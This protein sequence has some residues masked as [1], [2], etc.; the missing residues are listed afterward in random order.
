M[1]LSLRIVGIEL[2]RSSRAPRGIGGLPEASDN[3][4][5]PPIPVPTPGRCCLPEP[6]AGPDTR[7]NRSR[8]IDSD[9]AIRPEPADPRTL[10]RF[11]CDGS[12]PDRTILRSQPHRIRDERRQRPQR[13]ARGQA[14]PGDR[15]ID[16]HRRR[17]RDRVR[18]R[19]CARCRACQDRGQGG[20]GT[21]ADPRRGRRRIRGGAG[22][23]R[24]VRDRT[25]VQGRDRRSR[26][27]RHRRQQRG[28]GSRATVSSTSTSGT[29]IRASHCTSPRRC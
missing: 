28:G 2:E 22:P 1:V 26:R 24:P 21:R 25:D 18:G 8:L 13:S 14:G 29:G 19:G 6:P 9:V 7:R 5:R 20:A 12:E 4:L 3:R 11:G 10:P 23:C 15:G 16:R 27:H 17:D